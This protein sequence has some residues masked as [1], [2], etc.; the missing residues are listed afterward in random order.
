VSDTRGGLEVNDL[1]VL[2]GVR[3][4]SD[5]WLIETRSWGSMEVEA[6]L[7]SRCPGQV[8]ADL[9]PPMAKVGS[10]GMAAT[11]LMFAVVW[12]DGCIDR[13]E[14]AKAS[15]WAVQSCLEDG[16]S[17]PGCSFWLNSEI[18]L[19]KDKE[20]R[21]AACLMMCERE[22]S[23]SSAKAGRSVVYEAGGDGGRARSCGED[24]RR[25]GGIGMY[26]WMDG[27]MDK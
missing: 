16:E 13:G 21:L 27:R 3:L 17:A 12:N 11:A 10:K 9:G 23:E 15:D 8:K 2:G 18:D 25:G 19:R 20:P 24:I 4:G 7:D 26:V 22:S 6:G 1:V 14:V 5:P